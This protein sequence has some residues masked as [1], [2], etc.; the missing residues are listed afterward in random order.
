M[1]A[2]RGRES[3]ADEVILH[4]DGLVSEGSHSSI[5][6]IV[7][8]ALVVPSPT[9]A[10][11]VL[12]GTMSTLVIEAADRI[13]LPVSLRALRVDELRA[14]GGHGGGNI[15]SEGTP[16]QVAAAGLGATA[17]HI[18]ETLALRNSV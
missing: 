16:E 6:A 14:E 18:A 2:M 9:A 11:C 3:G 17:P 8:D 1:A 13:G 5:V 10:P 4:R 12:P 7:H 15:V